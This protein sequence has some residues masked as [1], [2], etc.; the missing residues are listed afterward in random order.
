MCGRQ[1]REGQPS[2]TRPSRFCLFNLAF[3]LLSL[4]AVVGCKS[5]T[6]PSAATDK[7]YENL[8]Q[9]GAAYSQASIKLGR[10]PGNANELT[11]IL[12][13]GAASRDP[14]E[15]LRSPDDNEPYVIVWGVD[16][17]QL[18][19]NT[20]NVDVVLAYEQ[21]GKNGKRH[22][23]KPPSNV[24]IMTDEEFKAAKFPP[25]HQPAP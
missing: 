22:V 1:I 23:L 19:K 17:R 7:S 11:E 3:G 8:Q 15:V 18:A 4:A 14:A 10:P 24:F 6:P 12:K 5:A 9:I 13:N 2:V 21:R 16:F 25:G 20:G